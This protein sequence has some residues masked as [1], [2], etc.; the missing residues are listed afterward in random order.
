MGNRGRTFQ[1]ELSSPEEKQDRGE[2]KEAGGFDLPGN[3]K[4]DDYSYWND[5]LRHDASKEALILVKREHKNQFFVPGREGNESITLY[6]ESA[7]RKARAKSLQ[8]SSP[9]SGRGKVVSVGPC[10]LAWGLLRLV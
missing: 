1:A 10:S 6:P 8:P 5:Y 2:R 7:S 4:P 3:T 9:F